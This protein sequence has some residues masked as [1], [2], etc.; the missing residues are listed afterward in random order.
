MREAAAQLEIH[1]S[2]DIFGGHFEEDRSEFNIYANR[3]E[4]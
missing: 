3:E 4:R 1:G 2:K